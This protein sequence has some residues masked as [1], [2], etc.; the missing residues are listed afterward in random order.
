VLPHSG[1][2][3]ADFLFAIFYHF[4]V[5]INSVDYLNYTP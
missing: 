5:N 2:F 1:H 4:L 3:K